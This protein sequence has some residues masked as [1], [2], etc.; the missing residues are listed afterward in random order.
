MLNSSFTYK[1]LKCNRKIFCMINVIK[2]GQ[3]EDGSAKYDKKFLNGNIINLALVDKV[4]GRQ[5]TPI[6]KKVENLPFLFLSEPFPKWSL[7]IC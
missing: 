6:H 5:K 2:Q 1:H 3:P 4:G 7:L